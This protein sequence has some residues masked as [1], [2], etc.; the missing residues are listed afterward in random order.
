MIIG[1]LI[2]DLKRIVGSQEVKNVSYDPT[3][4]NKWAYS[5]SFTAK[6]VP[7]A[8]TYNVSD[9]SDKI[10]D[11]L[12]N[13]VDNTTGQPKYSSVTQDP[14]KSNRI[15]VDNR[16]FVLI[17]DTSKYNPL[18]VQN[19]QI[20]KLN[21]IFSELDEQL[22]SPFTLSIG[23]N[24]YVIDTAFNGGKILVSPSA[25]AKSDVILLTQ[26]AGS[27]YISLKANSFQQWSGL[28]DFKDNALVKNFVESVNLQKQ[29]TGWSRKVADPLLVNK[30]V[31]GK[32][33]GGSFGE[34]NVNHVIIGNPGRISYRLVS[35]KALLTATQIYTNGETV[36]NNIYP[37][38]STIN[39]SDRSD[40]SVSNVRFYVWNGIKGKLI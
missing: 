28:S 8:I 4:V 29:K 35:G 10:I 13:L 21:S 30:F 6:V 18:R 9:I 14:N 38:F 24:D 17:K 37:H 39:S 16:F 23:G 1:T 34:D 33:Y 11:E 22:E 27:V 31:Y 32:N 20:N 7:T 12:T 25:K 40:F 5:T 15:V 3:N 26:N 36:A 2:D 19:L